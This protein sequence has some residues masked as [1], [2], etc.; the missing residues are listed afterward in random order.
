MTAEAMTGPTAVQLAIQL[1][2]SLDS[3]P[4]QEEPAPAAKR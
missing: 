2:Q 1:A 4:Q 3:V